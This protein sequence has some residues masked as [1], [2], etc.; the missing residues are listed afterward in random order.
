MIDFKSFTRSHRHILDL[1]LAIVLSYSA[2]PPIH[3]FNDL[4]KDG[5]ASMYVATVIP[6]KVMN[7]CA[8]NGRAI[9]ELI[10]SPL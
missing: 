7:T 5:L 6:D 9:G 4:M 8:K 3:S 2:S 1:Y 10:K